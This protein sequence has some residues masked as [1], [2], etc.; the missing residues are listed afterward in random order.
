MSTSDQKLN[1]VSLIQCFVFV[2]KFYL[3]FYNRGITI[4]LSRS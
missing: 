4:V 3:A 1:M 2:F